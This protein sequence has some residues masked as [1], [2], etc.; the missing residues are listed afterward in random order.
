M[1]KLDKT[2]V[3]GTRRD[4]GFTLV[5]GLVAIS[6]IGSLGL[7]LLGTFSFSIA[8]QEIARAELEAARSSAEVLEILRATSF[9]ALDI[10]E[11]GGF[12]ID[13]LGKFQQ[14]VIEDIED[15]LERDGLTLYLTIEPYEGRDEAKLITL[16][17]V[18]TGI[19]PRTTM[20]ELPPGKIMVKHTTIVTKRGLNP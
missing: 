6:L 13:P 15:R 2:Y 9:D 20:V 19:S 7:L 11:D 10:V 3:F 17:I 1:R 12:G 16:T 14:M 5:E 4:A 18:S 8:S